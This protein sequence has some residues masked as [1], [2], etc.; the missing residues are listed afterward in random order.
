[1]RA[2]L[3]GRHRAAARRARQGQPAAD[4][5]PARVDHRVVGRCHHQ[6]VARRHHSKLERRRRA[7][8]RLHGR[9]GGRPPHLADHPCRSHRRGRPHHRQPEG[10]AS[11]SST[12]KPSALRSDGR[13]ILVSLTISPIK[14]EAGNVDRRV[15]DRAR[16]HAPAAGRAARAPAAGGSRRGE[17]QVPGVLRAGRAVRRDHGPE[18]HDP[19]G[20][21]AVLGRVRLHAGSRSSASRSGKARGG[22]PR[23]RWWNRSRRR[24]RRPPP[25][26]RSAPRCRTSSPT[27]ASG[28]PTSRSSRSRTTP[29]ECCF[30]PRPASTSPTASGPRPIARSSSR[31]S[32][33]APTSSA[34]ATCNGIPFFVNR[35][36]LEMVGLDDIE[37]GAPHA[38]WHRS[39]SRKI[40]PGS[41][42]SSFRRCWNRATA[43]SRCASGIS[44]P[45]KRAGWPT[46]C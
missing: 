21:P 33:T 7:A 17:R 25:G 36:G 13:R 28:S 8:L 26:R 42:R 19:R 16:R 32:R 39:S 44:R 38:R 11:G 34:C 4:R 15:Q 27:A 22:R 6:Q 46:R 5:P 20:E 41:W 29:G 2:D 12:S 24:R 31:W 45:A 14:D 3:P 10:R 1:M 37:R 30:W 23:R 43:R 40:K 9:A 18:R 35:A